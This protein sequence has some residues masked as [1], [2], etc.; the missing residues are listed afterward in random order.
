MS[1]LYTGHFIASILYYVFC[2]STTHIIGNCFVPTQGGVDLLLSPL[3][4]SFFPEQNH[5]ANTNCMQHKYTWIWILYMFQSTA[6]IIQNCACVQVRTW[7]SYS[8]RK[9]HLNF[10]LWLNPRKHMQL[11]DADIYMHKKYDYIFIACTVN[12]WYFYKSIIDFL[13]KMH[14]NISCHCFPIMS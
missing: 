12:Q 13:H 4:R 7:S 5:T 10:I 2:I 9:K 11:A 1:F 8:R 14:I 3:V 6:K